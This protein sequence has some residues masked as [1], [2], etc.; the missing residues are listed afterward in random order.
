MLY[1]RILFQKVFLSHGITYSYYVKEKLGA[2]EDFS[3]F[4]QHFA[5]SFKSCLFSEKTISKN[6][7][8]CSV[9]QCLKPAGTN[10]LAVVVTG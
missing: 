4:F 6:D 5:F 10:P 9:F 7:D 8:A 2:Q 1:T 3:I